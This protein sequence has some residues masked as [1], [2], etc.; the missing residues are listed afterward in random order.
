M[1]KGEAELCF[2]LLLLLLLPVLVELLCVWTVSCLPPP[3]PG[4]FTYVT[5]NL[6]LF[7]CSLF[8]VLL[9]LNFRPALRPF[10]LRKVSPQP[11][12]V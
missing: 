3:Q 6:G 4:I 1:V 12:A 9:L 8:I 5:H 7:F 10:L 11:H 2:F